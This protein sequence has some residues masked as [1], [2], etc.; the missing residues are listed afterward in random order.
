MSFSPQKN[1]IVTLKNRIKSPHSHQA[2]KVFRTEEDERASH[3]A[4]I[5]QK[6]KQRLMKPL[7]LNQRVKARKEIGATDNDQDSKVKNLIDAEDEDLGKLFLVSRI[8]ELAMIS[9]YHEKESGAFKKQIKLR[10]RK[11]EG[12]ILEGHLE[13]DLYNYI[14]TVNEKV[15]ISKNL[16]RSMPQEKIESQVNSATIL[17]ANVSPKCLLDKQ[18]EAVRDIKET[19]IFPKQLNANVQFRHSE[20]KLLHLRLLQSMDSGNKPQMTTE[21]FFKQEAKREKERKAKLKL[22]INNTKQSIRTPYPMTQPKD[23]HGQLPPQRIEIQ[24]SSLLDKQSTPGGRNG[25]MYRSY[26]LTGTIRESYALSNEPKA[27][28][29]II[30]PVDMATPKAFRNT[31]G[32]RFRPIDY[33]SETHYIASDRDKPTGPCK[34]NRS[35]SQPF[36]MNM[37]DLQKIPQ[38]HYNQNSLDIDT[39]RSDSKDKYPTITCETYDY[40]YTD[41]NHRQASLDRSQELKV[42]DAKENKFNSFGLTANGSPKSMNETDLISKFVVNREKSQETGTEDSM[43]LVGRRTRENF[44]ANLLKNIQSSKLNKAVSNQDMLNTH[45]STFFKKSHDIEWGSDFFDPKMVDSKRSVIPRVKRHK[46]KGKLKTFT[47]KYGKGFDGNMQLEEQV[48]LR[49]EMQGLLNK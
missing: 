24:S 41:F 20:R 48:P 5:N 18:L 16:A 19:R 3:V 21:E 11:K 28:I 30:D 13:P 47:D 17:S 15:E 44:R 42:K 8:N 40:S 12:N 7:Q 35:S 10:K 32:S 46:K 1:A 6:Y 34:S 27:H 39:V 49:E 31:A 14:K 26:D 4:E 36:L 38:M 23:D 25:I 45:S 37:K 43:E 29:K 33:A 9:A 2:G 22:A